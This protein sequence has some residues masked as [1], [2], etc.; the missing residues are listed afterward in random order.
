MKQK[1]DKVFVGYDLYRKIKSPNKVD[2]T[3]KILQEENKL[4]RQSVEMYQKQI[5][6]LKRK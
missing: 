4:L 5:A 6:K 2:S 1:N 3:I